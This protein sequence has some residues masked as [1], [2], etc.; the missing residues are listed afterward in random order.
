VT[1]P[2]LLSRVSRLSPWLFAVPFA[3]V[4][5]G[6]I[7][8]LINWR[9]GVDSTVYRSGAVA[10]LHGEPLYD[11]MSLSG[12]PP[13]AR[14]PFT[15]PPTAALLFVPL[16]IF[17]TQVS[18]GLLGAVSMLGLSAVI[19]LCVRAIP[20]RPS[21][22]TPGRTAV[23]L[24]VVAMGIEPV[25][26]TIFLGQIN[27]VLMALVVVDVLVLRGRRYGGILTGVA[28]A[29]KLTPLVFL[30][31][32]LITGRRADALRALLTFVALQGLLLLLIP[33]DF[34]RF[35]AHAVT[36]PGR[37]GPVYWAG[38]QSLNGLVLRLTNAAPWS[39]TVAMG[40]AAVLAVPVA[41]VVRRLH[42]RGATVPAMLVTAFFGL[43]ASPVSWSHHWVWVVP[44][45][46]YLLSRVPEPLPEGTAARFAALGGIGAVVLVFASCVLLIMRNGKAIE[47]TWS[48]GEFV[49]GSSYLL[50][51]VVAAAFV[52]IRLGKLR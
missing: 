15:Y 43:L 21:W 49:F 4:V 8:W 6:V 51:P 23:V 32:L 3:L 20:N 26:R 47:L 41:I 27:L 19:A 45:I 37:T 29:V 16:A 22:L 10:L 34:V 31:Y 18:W 48:P 30:P 1:L 17:P 7:C 36:D 50:V 11:A 14:L 42:K 46:V 13:W 38:N 12:E 33:H 39:L 25:W 28:A 44:L 24:S 52:V 2:A 40:I 5:T 9:L 35:W